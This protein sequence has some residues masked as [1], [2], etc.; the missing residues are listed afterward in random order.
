MSRSFGSFSAM[1]LSVTLNDGHSPIFAP[2]LIA[3]LR[4]VSRSTRSSIVEVRK[5]DGMPITNNSAMT[6]ITAAMAAPAI[7][8]ALISTFQT[9]QAA[10]NSAAR[11]YPANGIALKAGEK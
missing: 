6:T 9:G 10:S 5:E 4:P 7:F 1:S 11:A 3:S 2:P 8:S